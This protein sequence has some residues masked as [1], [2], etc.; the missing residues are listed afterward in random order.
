M[1]TTFANWRANSIAL[2]NSDS[3][4]TTVNPIVLPWSFGFITTG[5]TISPTEGNRSLLAKETQLGV[6]KSFR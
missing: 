2:S 3:S 6:N 5:N 1:S 4:F